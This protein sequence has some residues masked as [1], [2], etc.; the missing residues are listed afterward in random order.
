MRTVA[1]KARFRVD[2]LAAPGATARLEAAL[3]AV[4]G[5]L[6]VRFDP[7][8]PAAAPSSAGTLTVLYQ[9]GTVG[10]ETLHAAI[11]AAGFT[12]ITTL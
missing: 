9:P 5:V 7:I 3:T 4:Q 2:G 12:G 10:P 1:I 6:R 8:P 11:R